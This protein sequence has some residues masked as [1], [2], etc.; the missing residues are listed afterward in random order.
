MLWP[1]LSE[2]YN[3]PTITLQL[4]TLRISLIIIALT[5]ITAPVLAL[6]I[7]IRRVSCSVEF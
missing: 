3:I 7:S 2:K 6:S 1:Q 5:P 4:E